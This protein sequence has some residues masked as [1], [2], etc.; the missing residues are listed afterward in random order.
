MRRAHFQV[1]AHGPPPSAVRLT[2]VT[3]YW[4]FLSGFGTVQ[5]AHHDGE[6]QYLANPVLRAFAGPEPRE[7]RSGFRSRAI[8]C[9]PASRAPVDPSRGRSYC[10]VA[11]SPTISR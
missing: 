11:C 7:E 5:A 1:R 3:A 8:P 6:A 4:L 9:R 2:E 10:Q